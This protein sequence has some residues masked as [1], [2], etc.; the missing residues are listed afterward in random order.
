MCGYQNSRFGFVGPQRF[1]SAFRSSDSLGQ[2]DVLRH[3]RDPLGVD[4]AQVG[5]LEKTN[6]VRFASLLQSLDGV[7]L[8]AKVRFEILRDLANEALEGQFADEKFGGL[9]VS[10]D[11]P[12]SNGAGP[13]AMGLLNASR[14]GSALASGLSRQLL[15]RGLATGRL[16]SGLLSACHFRVFVVDRRRMKRMKRVAYIIPRSR[17]SVHV[18]NLLLRA[19]SHWFVKVEAHWLVTGEALPHSANWRKMG[20]KFPFCGPQSKALVP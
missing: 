2:L 17:F 12:Q 19:R 10:A 6:Q 13:V 18:H 15:S 16:A 14:G 3:D 7:A 11:L 20:G 9:L 8:E 4:S 1:S 5:V